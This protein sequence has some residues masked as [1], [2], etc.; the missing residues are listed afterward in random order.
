MVFWVAWWTVNLNASPVCF[1]FPVC[2]N[3][4]ALHFFLLTQWFS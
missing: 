3:S 2:Y 1:F 4:K